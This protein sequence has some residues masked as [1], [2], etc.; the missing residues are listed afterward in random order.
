M[1]K[2]EFE[3]WSDVKGYEGL[4][5]VSTWGR[6]RSLGRW[7]NTNIKNSTK[8]FIKSKIL[9]PGENIKGYSQV[10]LYKEGKFKNFLVHRLVSQTFISNPNNL[11][12]VNHKDEDKENNTVD[13]L[14]WCTSEYN[15][16]Y[17]THNERVTK[18]MSKP[19]YQY[20]EN[21]DL[22]HEWPSTMECGRNG[23]DSSTVSKC[24]RGE[25]KRYKG[26][27]WSYT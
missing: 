24:C 12:E 19:V 1:I 16:N 21:Y 27:Y 7:V 14:E 3:L 26:F 13:N 15:I 18:A 17:G 8:R 20:D 11:P 4:Y 25:R 23:F 5:Q 10:R 9:K 6:V 22:V 2:A